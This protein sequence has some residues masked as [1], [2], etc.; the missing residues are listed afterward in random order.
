[1]SNIRHWIIRKQLLYF[2]MFIEFELR[3]FN[4]PTT[5]NYDMLVIDKYQTKLI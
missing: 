3:I 1:M 2:K 5:L 4:R